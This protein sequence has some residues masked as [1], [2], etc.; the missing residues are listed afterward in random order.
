MPRRRAAREMLPCSAASAARIAVRVIESRPAACSGHGGVSGRGSARAS[1][2][3]MRNLEKEMHSLKAERDKALELQAAR[4]SENVKLEHLNRELAHQIMHVN[5]L[6]D[7]LDALRSRKVIRPGDAIIIRYLGL[8]GRIG[9]TAFTFQ[10][11]LK[12]IPE[13]FN[14]CAIITDGRFSGGTVGLSVGYVSPEAALGGTLALA[15]DGDEIKIDVPARKVEL[16]VSDEELQ[17]RAE[18][19]QWEFP[20]GE[21]L[22][23]LHMFSKNVGSMAKGGVWDV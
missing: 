9:T 5:S 21:H 22:R 20:K 19:F 17:K 3:L 6:Q 8:K 13:L 2:I 1:R 12:G 16:H 18:A 4:E 10:E 14:S 23:Y 7:S 11:E 15:Q